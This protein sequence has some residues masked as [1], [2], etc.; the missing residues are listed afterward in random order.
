VITQLDEIEGKAA[1]DGTDPQRDAAALAETE[2]AFDFKVENRTIALTWKNLSA[3][4]VNYYLMDPEFLFSSS[5][6]ASE[7]PARFAIIKPTRAIELPLPAGQSAL[8]VPLPAEF[9]RANV[10]VEILATGKRQAQ[11]YH[12]NSLR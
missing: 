6:F 9:A 2:P 5:P 4:T 7:D 10:L 3:V 1:P 8:E 11:A 12:A